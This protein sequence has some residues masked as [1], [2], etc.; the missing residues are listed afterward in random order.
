M[1]SIWTFTPG[2]PPG[3]PS[4][5]H[6]SPVEGQRLDGL[7]PFNIDRIH[8]ISSCLLWDS[9]IIAN[10]IWEVLCQ[11]EARYNLE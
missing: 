6:E 7:S 8:A 5:D 4:G 9:H 2:E 11:N 3:G 10:L 1:R